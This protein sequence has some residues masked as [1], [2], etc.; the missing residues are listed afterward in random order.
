MNIALGVV[1]STLCGGSLAGA[2][3]DWRIEELGDWEIGRLGDWIGFESEFEG[4]CG[5]ALK[6]R[7][8]VFWIS[9]QAPERG[10]IS[11]S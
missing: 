7:E 4:L 2:L 6:L 9:L 10:F 1:M 8:F 3:G 11:L 5:G